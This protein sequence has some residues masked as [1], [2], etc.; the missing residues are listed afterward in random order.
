MKCRKINGRWITYQ[1]AVPD[2]FGAHMEG[3]R[4]TITGTGNGYESYL[5]STRYSR[6]PDPQANPSLENKGLRFEFKMRKPVS[7]SIFHLALEGLSDDT[8]EYRRHG[9]IVRPGYI[10]TQFYAGGPQGWGSRVVAAENGDAEAMDQKLAE[11]DP[12]ATYVL[13]L[14]AYPDGS[15]I[16][17]WKKGDPEPTEP[18][19]VLLQSDF[20][21]FNWHAW[22]WRETADV[23]ISE[24][25]LTHRKVLDTFKTDDAHKTWVTGLYEVLGEKVQMTTQDGE[26]PYDE[27]GSFVLRGSGRDWSASVG[28]LTPL[29]RERNFRV[30]VKV[31]VDT[32]VTAFSGMHFAVHGLSTQQASYRRHA[33][34]FWDRDIIAQ[35]YGSGIDDWRGS[36][37]HSGLKADTWYNLELVG[38]RSGTAFTVWPDD[39]STAKPQPQSILFSTDWVPRINLWVYRGSAYFKDYRV[40][41]LDREDT[42]LD[43]NPNSN[44]Y[45][46]THQRQGDLMDYMGDS[47]RLGLFESLIQSP[48]RASALPGPLAAI[49][50]LDFADARACW[51]ALDSSLSPKGEDGFAHVRGDGSWYWE[52]ISCSEPFSRT[53]EHS[54]RFD[55]K[56]PSAL[57][58]ESWI[59]L[60]GYGSGPGNPYRRHAFVLQ[61]AGDNLFQIRAQ[62]YTADKGWITTPVTGGFELGAVY[63][64]SITI[65]PDGTVL[66]LRDGTGKAIAEDSFTTET[67]PGT[68]GAASSSAADWEPRFIIRSWIDDIGIRKIK[69]Q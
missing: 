48:T 63:Q 52:G 66:T 35:S 4:L 12:A 55:L 1:G 65:R 3:G 47:C 67:H 59:G 13:K 20:K 49:A 57:K 21:E 40:T 9:I 11:Y 38:N 36:V 45:N 60:Q 24:Y 43:V 27:D 31:K 37:M 68:Y 64:M 56:L 7:D 39:G 16:Y 17:L 41:T 50:N 2:E 29:P 61:P 10:Y 44:H 26:K 30:S 51:Q 28:L 46:L 6:A 33:V 58:G 19:H 14:E 23:D 8:R 42:D 5:P 18:E 62:K 15:A 22:I 25:E 34:L 54:L 32:A 69:T 53:D